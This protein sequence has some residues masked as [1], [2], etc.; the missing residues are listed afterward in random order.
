MKTIHVKQF[1]VYILTMTDKPFNL[2]KFMIITYASS[3]SPCIIH[4]R[5][6]K[7]HKLTDECSVATQCEKF[8]S[9]PKINAVQY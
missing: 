6:Y 4:V 9:D 2:P 1:Y 3:S 7:L 5:D 8:N